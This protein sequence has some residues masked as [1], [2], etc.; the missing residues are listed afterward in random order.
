MATADKHTSRAVHI[1][2]IAIV[3]GILV[4][5][6]IFLEDPTLLGAMIVLWMTFIAGIVLFLRRKLNA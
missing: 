6:G 5:F 3:A 4:N 2:L 1:G